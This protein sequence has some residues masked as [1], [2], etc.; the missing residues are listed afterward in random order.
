MSKRIL[1]LLIDTFY[2]T[3]KKKI[4]EYIIVNIK[5]KNIN[6]DLIK[7]M[8]SIMFFEMLGCLPCK[9]SSNLYEC[10]FESVN[11][12]ILNNK[13][14]KEFYLAGQ[15]ENEDKTN[16]ANLNIN[17]N[18][19]KFN[20]FVD[21]QIRQNHDDKKKVFF[22]NYPFTINR[23][24]FAPQVV[25][26][27]YTLLNKNICMYKII[28]PH[29]FKIISTFFKKYTLFIKYKPLNSFNFIMKLN[30]SVLNSENIKN[31]MKRV[32]QGYGTSILDDLFGD[33]KDDENKR[34]NQEQKRFTYN[35]IYLLRTYIQLNG[36]SGLISNMKKC[37]NTGYALDNQRIRDYKWTRNILE[38]ITK[39]CYHIDKEC[40]ASNM[41]DS[42]VNFDIEENINI[43]NI[44]MSKENNSSSCFDGCTKYHSLKIFNYTLFQSPSLLILIFMIY[45]KIRMHKCINKKEYFNLIEKY[46]LGSIISLRKDYFNYARI[47]F[48]TE[49]EIFNNNDSKDYE[50]KNFDGV[51]TIE[52][53]NIDECVQIYD[54]KKHSKK[55]KII[56]SDS[57]N[58]IIDTKYFE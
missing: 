3:G 18:S 30:E 8:E 36:T 33:E 54:E 15:N 34:K 41:R 21:T 37:D 45:K 58:D 47:M 48:K 52:D 6:D 16:I 26:K 32:I 4:L 28:P 51:D 42:S 7:W 31:E 13:E 44:C 17:S 27:D 14:I 25:F 23:P 40:Q 56:E 22:K 46:L 9:E 39:G 20:N 50:I 43:D 29:Y 53:V 12:I 57:D 38:W 2:L 1:F 5:N 35:K 19:Y 55:R 11:G 49:S 24:L 10:I